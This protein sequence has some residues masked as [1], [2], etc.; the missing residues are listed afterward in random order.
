MGLNNLAEWSSVKSKKT[1]S[2][3]GDMQLIIVRAMTN[4]YQLHFIDKF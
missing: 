2:N 4:K 1:W 3:V